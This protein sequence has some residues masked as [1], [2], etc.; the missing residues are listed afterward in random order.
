[1][2]G[3]QLPTLTLRWGEY[4]KPDATDDLAIVQLTQAALSGGMITK[5]MALEKIQATFS[6]EN[7]DEAL[8]AVEEEAAQNKADALEQSGAEL[9]QMHSLSENLANGGPKKPKGAGAAGG[10][11][12][13]APRN[14]GK[15]GS[16]SAPKKT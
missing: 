6:I 13:K 3:W 7:V 10:A 9:E 11:N 5:R 16:G 12:K 4:F 15:S 1:M 14:S 8:D 2:N